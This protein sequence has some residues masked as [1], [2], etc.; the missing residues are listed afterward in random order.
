MSGLRRKCGSLD[1]TLR[2]QTK[3]HRE[4]I[5]NG[6]E[7]GGRRAPH[8]IREDPVMKCYV[9]LY[10]EGAWGERRHA[11]RP[12][13]WIEDKDESICVIYSQIMVKVHSVFGEIYWR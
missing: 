8:V 7:N 11:Y 13:F 6:E 9:L 10:A 3:Q 2:R 1:L 5:N 4:K 12:V